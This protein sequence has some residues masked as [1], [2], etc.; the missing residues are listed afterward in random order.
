MK[1][2]SPVELED[3][4]WKAGDQRLAATAKAYQG[5]LTDVTNLLSE[6]KKLR[7]KLAGVSAMVDFR[8]TIP[9]PR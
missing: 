3:Y 9:K 6:V 4:A 7:G 1:P 2:Y 8:A 5:A